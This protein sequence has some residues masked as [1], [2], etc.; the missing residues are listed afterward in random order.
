MNKE[1]YIGLI[2]TLQKLLKSKDINQ[3]NNRTR[4]FS[5]KIAQYLEIMPELVEYLNEDNLNLKHKFFVEIG[6]YIKYQKYQKGS[7]I[8]H[9]CEG[10]KIFYMVFTG[11]ILKLNIKYK[12][13]YMSLKEYILFL[14]KLYVLNENFLYNDCIKKNQVVFPIKENIDIIKFGTKIKL[15]DFKEELKNIIKMKEEILMNNNKNE[16]RNINE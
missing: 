2:S 4:V 11:K 5:E 3:D 10:D 1:K 12:N 16:R 7:I 6:R 14:A 9:A 8:Q 15:F 13:I